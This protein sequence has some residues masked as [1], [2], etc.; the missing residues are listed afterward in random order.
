MLK[1]LFY[2][3]AIMFMLVATYT[4]AAHRAQAQSG[5]QV[6]GITWADYPVSGMFAVTS[7]GTVYR[8]LNN[9][10]GWTFDSRVFGGGTVGVQ[11]ETWTGVKEKYRK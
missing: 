1:K 8:Y 7:D 11:P 10:T 6:V 4:V 9:G 3:S 2:I 5:G